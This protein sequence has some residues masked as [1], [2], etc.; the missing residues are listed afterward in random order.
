M[1]KSKFSLG[2]E[3]AA[4]QAAGKRIEAAAKLDAAKRR[5]GAAVARLK[6]AETA[7]IAE[8]KAKAAAIA[9]AKATGATSP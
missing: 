5:F 8:L 7:R 6:E 1:L 3:K 9:A 2:A 4:F